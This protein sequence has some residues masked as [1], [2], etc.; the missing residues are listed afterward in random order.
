MARST[1]GEGVGPHARIQDINGKGMGVVRAAGQA[2]Q[3]GE[4]M[5]MR[6]ALAHGI[7]VTAVGVPRRSPVD[8][9]PETP[10][11]VAVSG[12]EH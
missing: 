4:P 7:G 10:G 11:P 1:E 9:H 8:A 5:P 3:L 6:Q 12:A 2:H